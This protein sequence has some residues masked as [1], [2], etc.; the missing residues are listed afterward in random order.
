MIALDKLLYTI[1]FGLML[2]K[3]KHKNILQTISSVLMFVLLFIAIYSLE[4]GAINGGEEYFRTFE[5]GTRGGEG[6]VQL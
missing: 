5:G 2:S 4:L 3:A 1:L 6:V